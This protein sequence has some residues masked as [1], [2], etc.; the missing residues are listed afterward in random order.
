MPIQ[1]RFSADEA[2]KISARF[3]QIVEDADD[4]PIDEESTDEGDI[5]TFAGFASVG[6]QP[7]EIDGK[8]YE[9]LPDDND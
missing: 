8:P 4:E 1:D 5:T 3:G 7:R 6:V 2:E 9:D